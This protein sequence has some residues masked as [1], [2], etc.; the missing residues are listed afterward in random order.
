LRLGL[1]SI[2]LCINDGKRYL[3]TYVIQKM[4]ILHSPEQ[5][6]VNE[7][8]VFP[9]RFSYETIELFLYAILIARKMMKLTFIKKASFVL[10]AAIL[11]AFCQKELSCEGCQDNI[12]PPLALAGPD[13]VITLPTDSV[14][15][16]GSSSSDPDGKISEWQWTKI[17]GP[18]SFTI[19][20]TTAAKTAVK[21]LRAGIYQFELLVKDDDGLSA[22][23]TVQVVVDSVPG[24]NHPPLADAGPDTTI[25][26]PLNTALLDGS[27]SADPDSNITAYQW[28]TI[29]G[30]ATANI[31]APTAVQTQVANLAEGTYQFELK[32]TDAG[33]LFS[34]DTVQLAVVAGVA[35]SSC[36]SSRPEFFLTVTPFVT[37]R[38]SKPRAIGSI[39]AAGS[40]ILFAGGTGSSS[41]MQSWGETRVDIY[42]M[43]TNTWSIAEL[44]EARYQMAGIAA[45]NKII[46]AG[47]SSGEIGDVTYRAHAAVDIYDLST[48]TWSATIMSEAKAGMA[49]GTV[50]NKVL[51]AG[52]VGTL[53]VGNT[54]YFGHIKNKVEMYD[55]LTGE[56]SVLRCVKRKPIYQ[57]LP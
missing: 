20:N 23:D 49:A 16:D 5:H 42:D 26:L 55:L 17:E 30:P 14:L 33:G 31:A 54:T 38:L 57:R 19:I 27:R 12:Q 43:A 24:A 40:K 36:G 45:G 35:P 41:G 3:R 53:T 2:E 6:Q 46:L 1:L 44:S 10:L 29:A 7:P 48:N 18:A 34:K 51:F 32:V 52:G 56:W 47:G 50:G 15:L 37:G 22:K 21:N 11:F 13:G 25:L 39:V 4:L 28:T 8:S 9:P